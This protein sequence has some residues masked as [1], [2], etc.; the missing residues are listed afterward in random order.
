MQVQD[1]AEEVRYRAKLGVCL[2]LLQMSL[3]QARR[4][5]LVVLP[6]TIEQRSLIV[7][8]EYTFLRD[9]SSLS[10]LTLRFEPN[11]VAPGWNR[12]VT[13]FREMNF[14]PNFPVASR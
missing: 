9:K 2:N 5:A 14:D 3:R 12:V 1:T 7:A 13:T 10:P 11:R 8:L 4:V 6:G